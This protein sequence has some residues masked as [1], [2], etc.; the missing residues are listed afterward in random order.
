MKYLIFIS[1]LLISISGVSA[2]D[3]EK[4]LAEILEDQKDAHL[5]C[6]E[7]R[8]DTITDNLIHEIEILDT[9]LETLY[10]DKEEYDIIR[11]G[12]YYVAKKKGDNSLRITI[13]RYTGEAKLDRLF[14]D[15]NNTTEISAETLERFYCKKLQRLF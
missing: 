11:A 10:F 14:I 15:V 8:G 6:Y 9:Y 12:T 13:N 1:I 4:P 7:V 5:G 2:V 3:F